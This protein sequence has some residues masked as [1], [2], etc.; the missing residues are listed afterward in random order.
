MATIRDVEVV[1]MAVRV[2]RVLTLIAALSVAVVVAPTGGAGTRDAGQAALPT[3]YVN[4]TMNCTF[5]IVDDL[6]RPVTAIAPGTYQVE[7]TTPVF[8]KLAVPAG[9]A[10]NTIAANDFYGCKGWVQFQLTGPGVNLTTTL[11]VGCDAFLT[12]PATTFKP[13][14]TFTA[15]DLNQPSVAHATFTTLAS[16]TPLVPTSPYGKTS[17]KGSTQQ[18]LAGSAVKAAVMGTVTGTLSKNA[19]WPTLTNKGKAVSVIKAGRYRFTI[20]DQDPKHGVTLQ[21]VD[22]GSSM[23]TTTPKVSQD[24]TGVAFVGKHSTFVTLTPGQWRYFSDPGKAVYF[25][26]TR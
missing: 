19:K 14:S 21:A 7:V 26:V 17:G 15:Q 13:S 6:N 4:Y 3:L 25:R 8:F 5:S 11:D 2:R 24:L 1:P 23:I 20:T 22:T 9:G 10:D 18:Q 12:L 16:G